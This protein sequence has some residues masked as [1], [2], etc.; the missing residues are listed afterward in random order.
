MEA[1]IGAEI[2][3][4]LSRTFKVEF[5]GA[6]TA[7]TDLLEAGLVDSFAFVDLITFIEK[8]Y[9]VKLTGDDLASPE[10]ATLSGIVR[11]VSARIAST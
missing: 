2:K 3:D 5:G 7:D 1:A 10:I 8:T 6:V 4:F 11:L 9:G